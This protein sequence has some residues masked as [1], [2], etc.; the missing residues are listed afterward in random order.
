MK[1]AIIS[2]LHS[3]LDDTTA[4][5]RAARPMSDYV[6]CLGDVYECHIGKKRRHERFSHVEQVV[7]YDPVF[8]SLL[9]FPI[10]LGNQEE[11]IRDVLTV[12]HPV[13][14]RIRGMAEQMT[15][16]EAQFIHGHQVAWRDDWMPLVEKG[17]FPLVFVG[18]SHLPA[19]YRKGHAIPWDIGKPYRLTRKR[20][21]IN[22]GAVV[23]DR[24]WCL[25]DTEARTITRMKA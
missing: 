19:L 25:Y 11:R 4:V 13:L 14:S 18:H 7:T 2:D 1:L 6:L 8:E 3:H 22:V 15:I 5:L 17:P 20:Y 12:P 16:G 23:Y 9:T 24:E 21:T 10:L